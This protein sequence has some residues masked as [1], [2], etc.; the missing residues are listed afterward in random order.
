MQDF[1]ELRGYTVFRAHDGTEGLHLARTCSPQVCILDVMMPKMDGFELAKR[2]KTELP[3]LPILFL[4][5]KSRLPDKLEGFQ[6]GADDYITKPFSMEEVLARIQAVCRRYDGATKHPTADS[7]GP[8]EL[9]T[10]TLDPLQRRLAHPTLPDARKLSE[11]EA[12]LLFLLANHRNRLL[13]RELALREVWGADNYYTARSM[14]VYI[15]RL[16]KYLRDD[17]GLSIENVHGSGYMLVI[18]NR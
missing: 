16:R 7:T 11:K 13:P 2:I 1:L 15:S 18:A 10:Y 8:V 6:A 14:D 9:G 3:H 17:T 4:T 12:R 5:A